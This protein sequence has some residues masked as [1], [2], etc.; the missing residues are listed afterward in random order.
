METVFINLYSILYVSLHLQIFVDDERAARLDKCA[1]MAETLQIGLFGTIDVEMVGVCAGDDA[2]PRAEPVEGTVEFVGFDNHK[3]TL[4]RKD[5]VGSVVLGDSS[6]ESVAVDAA[7]VHDMR[8]HR[9]SGCLSVGPCHAKSLMCTGKHSQDLCAFFHIESVFLE[10][11]QFGVLLGNSRSVDN[12]CVAAILAC[13]RNEVHVF[14]IMNQCSL[15]FQLQGK[16]RRCLVVTA[17]NHAFLQEVACNGTH[18]DAASSYEIH[19]LYIFQ[20][21]F[22]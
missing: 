2:H 20:F 19:S 12:K 7:L 4:L 5:I 21:H 10:I 6:E 17:Y 1:V 11:H 18:A 15:F 22:A 14:F 13:F 3:V 8:T 16:C 9:G